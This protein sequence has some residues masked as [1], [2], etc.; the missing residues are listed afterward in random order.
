MDDIV[1]ETG[2]SKLT[3]YTRFPSKNALFSA[4]INRKC[5]D[6][7]PH[8]MNY[9]VSVD[10]PSED[11]KNFALGF[12]NLLLSEDALSMFRMMIVEAHGQSDLPAIFY[13]EG[14]QKVRDALI[15]KLSYLSDHKILSF[16]NIEFARDHF[17]SLFCGSDYHMRA[18]LKI[19]KKPSKKELKNFVETAVG[20][21]FECY[22]Y[23]LK[24]KRT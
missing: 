7:I 16:E 14:P 2:M 4:V 12:L 9:I 10:N 3:I 21:F 17:L 6:F 15:Y 19:G 20:Q 18:L 24:L 11:L 1:R 8:S 5:D 13:R 22:N 23:Q